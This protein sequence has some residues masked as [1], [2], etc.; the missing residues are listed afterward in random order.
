MALEV[1]NDL[2]AVFMT[3]FQISFVTKTALLCHNHPPLFLLVP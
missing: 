1:L 3:L 2:V